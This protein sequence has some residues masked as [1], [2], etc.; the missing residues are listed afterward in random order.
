VPELQQE[1]YHASE[2][3]FHNQPFSP[4]PDSSTNKIYSIST[5]AT[6]KVFNVV[7]R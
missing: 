2:A 4:M 6:G 1:F 3:L 5:V 7:K